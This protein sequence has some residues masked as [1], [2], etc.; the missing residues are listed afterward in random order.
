MYVCNTKDNAYYFFTLFYRRFCENIGRWHKS[1]N[2]YWI[3]DLDKK[4]IYQKCHDEDCSGFSSTPKSLPE[5]IIF[6]LDTEGDTF[7]SSV[8]IDENII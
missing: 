3:V 1:N 2:V 4:E 5:Q 8:K 6:M 7:I